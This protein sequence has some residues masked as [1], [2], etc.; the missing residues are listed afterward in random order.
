MKKILLV[1]V[2][3]LLVS[4]L[5]AID[6]DYQGEIRTR[7]AIYN[8]QYERDGGHVDSRLRL[9][10][11]TMLHP[12]LLLLAE[13]QF[14]DVIW[15]SLSSF[16][17]KDK[18]GYG[19]GIPSSVSL[20]AYQMYIDYRINAI[21]S[22]VRVGQQYWADNMGL[23]I[24]DS[25]SGVMLNM[26]D[27]AGFQTNFAWIKSQE[28]NLVDNDDYNY[29]LVNMQAS[30]PLPWGVFASYGRS[31]QL[32]YSTIT[33]MPFAEIAAGPVDLKA[34]VFAAL[35]FN[36]PGDDE[37]GFG[38]AVKANAKI[39]PIQVVGDLLFAT[40]NGIETLSPYYQNGLYIYGFGEHHDGVNLYWDSPYDY[41]NNDGV[42]S[43]VG[44]VGFQLCQKSKLFG[45]TGIVTD[46]GFELNAGIEYEVI[47]DLMQ[48]AAYGALGIATESEVGKA[49]DKPTNYLLGTTL[50]ITF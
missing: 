38:A 17:S 35:H 18:T 15:G 46:R 49:S 4:L 41:P 30:N 14:G 6:F 40:E 44:N 27:V 42:L 47:P 28:L 1:L 26:D 2:P 21:Q 32:D 43:L 29:F 7:G 45:A 36:D 13:L 34:N 20:S 25:F 8:D 12:Q 50:N 10:M 33:L 37:L 22:N 9:A 24:D 16:P 19:G 31:G 48:L 5:A 11:K 3:L 23:I 39:G